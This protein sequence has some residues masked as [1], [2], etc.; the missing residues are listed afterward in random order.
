MKLIL[1][2]VLDTVITVTDLCVKIIELADPVV[3]LTTDTNQSYKLLKISSSHKQPLPRLVEDPQ[4][5]HSISP[6]DNDSRSKNAVPPS[7]TSPDTDAGSLYLRRTLLDSVKDEIEPDTLCCS[8]GCVYRR[9]P[10]VD[11][12]DLP[13]KNEL[14][15]MSCSC[16]P[17]EAV[18]MMK[19][20][21]QRTLS[22][23]LGSGHQ[24]VITKD[25]GNAESW[26]ESHFIVSRLHSIFINGR[27]SS[28]S[29]T[30]ACNQIS[31]TGKPSIPDHESIK[32]SKVSRFV[33]YVGV[34]QDCRPAVLLDLDRF[35]MIKYDLPDTRL[36]WSNDSA[37]LNQFTDLMPQ[38][39]YHYKPVSLYPPLWRHDVSFWDNQDSQFS[40]QRLM[41]I[42]HDVSSD[43]LKC[44][45]LMNVW[46]EPST[47]KISHCYRQIYQSYNHAISHDFGHK[48]QNTVRLTL[49]SRL[50]VELR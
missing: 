48:L 20:V 34:T 47:G 37:V 2:N 30:V 24:V 19:D 9:R 41:D 40:E 7:C 21:I 49:A 14:L 50:A 43:A 1:T 4:I 16:E 29:V 10:V 44:V 8:Y 5:T 26:V 46:T 35:C 38:D 15:M 39:V 28:Q 31:E 36:L 6:T 25:T 17:D 11:C 12:C 18:I 22:M 23:V 13:M 3:Q 45:R 42:M 33:G 32:C 27:S